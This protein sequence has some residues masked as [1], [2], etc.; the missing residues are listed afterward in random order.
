MDV[1]KLGLETTKAAFP[2][3]HGTLGKQTAFLMAW[4]LH[5]LPIGRPLLSFLFSLYNYIYFYFFHFYEKSLFFG[6]F[7]HVHYIVLQYSHKV[8][9]GLCQVS[10]PWNLH[11]QAMFIQVWLQNQLS[12]IP[13]QVSAAS[14]NKHGVPVFQCWSHL[15]FCSNRIKKVMNQHAFKNTGVCC[16]QESQHGREIPAVGLKCCL[17]PFLVFA[18]MEARDLSVCS[19]Q[20]QGRQVT[21]RGGQCVDIKGA[22]DHVVL[23]W[24]HSNLYHTEVLISQP[25][26]QRFSARRGS[27]LGISIP[28]RLTFMKQELGFI[29]KASGLP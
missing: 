25:A 19:K 13:L 24:Q 28:H 16:R 11:S 27:L 18:L 20:S 1:R 10:P 4:V 23:D 26:L 17:M 9:Q 3:F 22:Q 12:F 2:Y 5:H 29:T 8:I 15:V 7:L 14:C 21:Y 6:N